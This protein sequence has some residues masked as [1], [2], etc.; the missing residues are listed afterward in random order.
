MSGSF[1]S[2][3]KETN[4]GDK[5]LEIENLLSYKIESLIIYS[6]PLFHKSL[7]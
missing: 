6:I 5:K 7:H 3:R 2:T 4:N 1:K